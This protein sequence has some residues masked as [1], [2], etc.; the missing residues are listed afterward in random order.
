MN[1]FHKLA[2]INRDIELLENAGKIKAAEIL[3]KKFIKE[4]QF[5]MPATMPAPMP[6][7]YN[8]MPAQM[9]VVYNPTPITYNPMAYRPITYQQPAVRMPTTQGFVPTPG[10]LPVAQPRTTTVQ[11]TGQN[12]TVSAPNPTTVKPQTAPSAQTNLA[13]VTQQT[14]PPATVPYDKYKNFYYD[15]QKGR[16]IFI[17]PRTGQPFENQKD[18]PKE[19]PAPAPAPAPAPSPPPPGS[20]P[21]ARQ[22][23]LGNHFRNKIDNYFKRKPLPDVQDQY[24]FIGNLEDQLRQYRNNGRLTQE[25]YDDL[26]YDLYVR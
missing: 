5:A 7:A 14:A 18:I 16:D 9:P 11:T 23:Q 25:Q 1:K 3:H 24:T 4:A 20:P 26:S 19:M 21:N 6:V 17:D 15:Q 13:P 12:P 2:E 8:P 10:A 22:N